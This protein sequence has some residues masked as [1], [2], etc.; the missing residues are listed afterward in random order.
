MKVFVD[1]KAHVKVLATLGVVVIVGIPAWVY[2]AI[3]HFLSPEGFW[4]E[5][6]LLGVGV[7]VLGGIQVSFAIVGLI[8]LVLIWIIP[9]WGESIIGRGVK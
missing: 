8:V 2:L 6:F 5:F 7:L 1:M 4:Q 3:R 9:E